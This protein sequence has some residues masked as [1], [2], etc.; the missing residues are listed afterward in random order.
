MYKL[1]QKLDEWLVK[2]APFQLPEHSKVTLVK[3]LPW[4]TLIGG[5]LAAIAVLN[6]FNWLMLAQNA[7]NYVNMAAQGYGYYSSNLAVA[8][9]GLGILL[10]EAILFFIAF[11][12]LKARKKLGWNLLYYVAAA[13]IAYSVLYLFIDTN[14]ASFIIS[15]FSSLIGLYLLFQIRNH[16][17]G[18]PAQAQK[19]PP[20]AT[21]SK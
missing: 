12:A 18:K 16:Y 13:N 17:V 1:E 11:P 5:V 14:I 21:P 20:A 2:K 6:L 4:L 15:L 10:L 8:W 3:M 9:L 19:T 7:S